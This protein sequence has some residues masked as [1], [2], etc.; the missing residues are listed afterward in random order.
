MLLRLL[1]FLT[2]TTTLSAAE[3]DSVEIGFDGQGCVGEWLP[4]RVT[5]NGQPAG[6]SALLQTEF[7]DPSGNLCVDRTITAVVPDDGQLR[8]E[9]LIR[10]GRLQG[11]GTV[12][13]IVDD[14]VAAETVVSYSESADEEP[15]LLL[16]TRSQTTFQP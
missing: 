7:A 1:T 5:L 16:G 11:T 6:A 14:K 3:F 2:L 10:I 8:M 12:S 15:A 4:L 9:G 13:L